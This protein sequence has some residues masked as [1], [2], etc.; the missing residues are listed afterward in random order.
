[1]EQNPAGHWTV[2]DLGRRF[3]NDLQA[4]FLPSTSPQPVEQHGRRSPRQADLC[5]D[6]VRAAD[7]A[8]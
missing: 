2:T 8:P 4:L 6:G 1:M 7:S 3:L 5:T